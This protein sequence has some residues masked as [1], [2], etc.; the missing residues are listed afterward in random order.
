MLGGDL[1]NKQRELTRIVV[2][3]SI[4][5]ASA[6]CVAISSLGKLRNLVG[7][8]AGGRGGRF[9]KDFTLEWQGGSDRFMYSASMPPPAH[10]T[11]LDGAR[12]A[13]LPVRVPLSDQRIIELCLMFSKYK[14]V[15]LLARCAPCV[16]S[17]KRVCGQQRRYPGP[18]PGKGL[19]PH[20]LHQGVGG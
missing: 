8:D 4:F 12:Q 14:G 7:V 20:V 1:A 5:S 17:Y 11:V 2:T 9:V 13:C 16:K 10:G 18:A 6:C 15:G 19:P 3:G